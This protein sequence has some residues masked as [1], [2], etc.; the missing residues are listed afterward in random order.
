MDGLVPFSSSIA[1]ALSSLRCF[2]NLRQVYTVIPAQM[3]TKVPMTPIITSFRICSPVTKFGMEFE[4]VV[5]TG[6]SVPE[7]AEMLFADGMFLFLMVMSMT[8]SRRYREGFTQ[9]CLCPFER[10]IPGHFLMPGFLWSLDAEWVR[11]RQ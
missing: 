9:H 3:T 5:G 7:R 11:P 8:D 2:T 1:A 4:I 6:M 10:G